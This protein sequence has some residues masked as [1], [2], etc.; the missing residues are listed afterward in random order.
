MSKAKIATV[1]RMVY[2]NLGITNQSSGYGVIKTNE[3]YPSAYV[4]DAIIGADLT[5]MKTLLKSKQYFFAPGFFTVGQIPS[6][7]AVVEL[8][9]HTEMLNVRFYYNTDGAEEQGVEIPWEMYE[10]F[11]EPLSQAPNTSSLFQFQ[12][13]GTKKYGGYFS[14]KDH[15]LWTIPFAGVPYKKLS[16]PVVFTVESPILTSTST[17]ISNSHGLLSGDKVI[18]STTGT[19]PQ[20]PEFGNIP[21]LDEDTVYVVENQD[22][23]TFNLFIPGSTSEYMEFESGGTGT[24]TFTKVVESVGYYKYIALTHP[25]SLSGNDL[26]SP[27]SFEEAIAFLASANLLMK[28]ADNP[29]Q[30]TFYLQQ[31]QVLM[32]L[33]MTPSTNQQRTIDE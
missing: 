32:G 8:P 5:V 20:V 19:Y 7:Y 28:R 1:K 18:V 17:L 26:Q 13:D 4:D 29:A 14:I 31:Y 25:A 9:V 23:D 11:T 30:A 15:T 16:N 10:M 12:G 24:L 2:E 21:E 33:Y 6:S 22:V 27:Q 3:R